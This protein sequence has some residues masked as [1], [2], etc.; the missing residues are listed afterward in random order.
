[1]PRCTVA[2]GTNSRSSFQIS[3]AERLLLARIADAE[4][5]TRTLLATIGAGCVAAPGLVVL[6]VLIPRR[7][8]QRRQQAETERDRSGAELRASEARG[9]ENGGRRGA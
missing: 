4:R 7:D 1:M 9:G 8:W 5:A 2:L 3:E 6:A